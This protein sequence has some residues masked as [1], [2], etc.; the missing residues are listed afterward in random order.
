MIEVKYDRGTLGTGKVENMA[1]IIFFAVVMGFMFLM[2][3]S[4][5]K[6]EIARRRRV[7]REKFGD[8]SGS[9]KELSKYLDNYAGYTGEEAR[10]D[11]VT[12]KDLSMCE[13]FRR[14]NR[15]DS[16]MGE[17][18]LYASLRGKPLTKEQTELLEKRVAYFESEEKVRGEVE[19]SLA[20]FGKGDAS[21]LIPSYLDG[22]SEYHMEHIW[23]YRL[24]QILLA[25]AAICAVIFHEANSITFLCIVV[26]VNIVTY[27]MTKSKYD[28]Q[29][30]MLGNVI[31]LF[32]VGGDIAKKCEGTGVCDGLGEKVAAFGRANR[33]VIKMQSQ[34]RSMF[35]GDAMGMM[36]DY[37]LGLTMWHVLAYEK[38]ICQLERDTGAYMDIYRM[39][40]ELD[41]AISVASFRKSLP[42]YAK[43]QFVQGKRLA[44]EEMYHPLLG[45][46]VCNSLT[47][48]QNC[49]ITGSN[50]SGKS[51]F[52]KAVAVNV[53]LAQTIHTVTAR[54]MELPVARMITSMAVADDIMSGESYFMKEIKYLKRILDLTNDSEVTICAI[55]EILRGTNT[56]ERIAASKAILNYLSEKNC[57]V[58]VASHDRELTEGFNGSYENYHFS[59]E[60][61]EEDILFDYK[62][63]SG[64]ANTKNAIRLLEYVKFP[65]TVIAE[66]RR[67]SGQ[68]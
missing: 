14:I 35:A 45:N 13:I 63:K 61:R 5:R 49:I 29:I 58:F 55:D 25:V 19:Y 34:R 12:W 57:I 18:I 67:L 64:P 37:L 62:I 60:F 26:V 9:E 10:V 6:V 32:K 8:A 22:I 30:D 21:Y 33:I 31:S 54:R 36:M 1:V 17:E 53:I 3:R 44:M 46:P 16:S 40:G 7:I 23:T 11:D 20:D 38:V 15:C 56:E 24:Q 66:S 68:A 65:E 39:L 28:L 47:L 41:M 52:I 51:T 27:I 59:E 2:G 48:E 50:A 43:P 42:F 4:G